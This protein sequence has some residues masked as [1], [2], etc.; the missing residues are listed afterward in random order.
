MNIFNKIWTSFP[1]QLLVVH[2]K[3]NQFLLVY[4]LILFAIVNGDFGQNLG[5]PY[6]FLDP[7][8]L[9]EV[10]IWGFMI[11]GVAIA[12]FA[13]SY[14]ITSYILDGFRFPFLGTLPRPLAHFCLNNATI[15]VAF[16]AFYIYKIIA[17][18]SETGGDDFDVLIKI[19]G[20]LIGC[21]SMLVFLFA[22]FFKTNF[23][24]FKL[25]SIKTTLRTK[26]AVEFKKAFKKLQMLRRSKVTVNYYWSLNLKFYSTRRFEEYYDRLAILKVFIQNQRNAIVIQSLVLILIFS[27][28]LFQNIPLFQIPAGASGVLMLTMIVMATGALSFWFRSWIF[29]G[30]MILFVI[31]NLAF[32][33]DFLSYQYPAYGLDY[34]NEST[35]YN[36][37]L[38][39]E[40]ASDEYVEPSKE[41]M[42]AILNNWKAKFE[43]EK[44]RMVLIAVSGGGQRSALWT[45]N[46]LQHVDSVF[47]GDLMNETFMMTGASGGLFGAAFYREL[48][49]KNLMPQAKEHL[50][51]ISKD[52]LNPV[53]FTL[54]VNDL[55]LKLRSFEYGGFKYKTERGYEFEQRLT[56]NLHGLLD[57][58][59]SAYREPEFNAEIPLIMMAPTI[60]N[61]GRKLYVSPQPTSF[62]NTGD[63]DNNSKIQGVDYKLLLKDH[64]PDSLRFLTAL[65]MSATFPYFSPAITLPTSPKIGIADAG[66]SDNYGIS[67]A[68]TFLHVF[69]DWIKENTSE[70]ILITIRD[71]NK[72]PPIESDNSKSLVQKFFSPIQGAVGSWD[73]VQT[74]KNE[75]RFDLI[76]AVYQGQLKR[77][78]F[79]YQNQNAIRA[80][81]SWRLTERE[82]KNILEGIQEDINQKALKKLT[83]R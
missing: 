62:F 49:W 81:L 39:Q 55:F 41:N 54:L 17:F 68:T 50:E 16:L 34:T 61:D 25:L 72:E 58:P 18:Q 27:L 2:V 64:H 8:Y 66:I 51:D 48:A 74:I 23:D 42:V 70:V 20:L 59:I 6:L 76:D 53:I 69:E 40:Y 4:W 63:I 1:V 21:L 67:D 36:L 29:S 35:E 13:M 28:G 78:E 43:E 73:Q 26:K 57:N 7:V 32:T 14:N 33:S 10:S 75:Q 47:G 11:L 9:D 44:P 38:L 46:V 65:R 79:E 37:G 71:S 80:S 83:E 12:G 82:I 60:T 5:I 19:L 31:L 52:V 77:V 15:P 30:I 3:H 24:V 22:Y 56:T 45:M